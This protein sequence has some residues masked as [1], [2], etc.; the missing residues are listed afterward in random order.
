M[1]QDCIIR[2]ASSR[3][4]R[5]TENL[6]REAFWN[7]YRP[8]C[9][10]HYILHVL[11]RDPAFVPEL[12]FVMETDGKIIG[13][14][15][16]VRAEI[17]SDDGRKIPVMTFGPISISPEFRRR[18]FGLRL[19]NFALE[20]AA[21]AGAGAVFIEGDAAFYGNA[22]FSEAKNFGIGHD[23]EPRGADLPFFLAKELVP[24]FLRGISGT[25]RTPAAYFVD[26]KDVGKFDE[27][28]PPK[29]KLRL[30]GQI[31]G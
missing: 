5:A 10:E 23:D 24:G 27:N 19:L 12:D 8:G 14:I 11:R 20:K 25:Y 9:T 6:T 13:Q 18:G 1:K 29:R 3:D 21:E 26:E 28:F 2:R 7:V 31:F 22:G 30:P 16:F 4:R 15:V 17:V